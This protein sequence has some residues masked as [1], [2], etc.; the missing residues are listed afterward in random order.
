MSNCWEDVS[1]C[2]VRKPD[3]CSPTIQTGVTHAKCPTLDI[4]SMGL[5]PPRTS[6]QPILKGNKVLWQNFGHNLALKGCETNNIEKVSLLW[7]ASQSKH[8]QNLRT[9]RAVGRFP[10]KANSSSAA[11][12]DNHQGFFPQRK[13]NF[14]KPLPKNHQRSPACMDSSERGLHTK[15]WKF[16]YLS[17]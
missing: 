15:S 16:F 1:L 9:V 6:L 2:L 12:G 8:L 10:R 4:H 13:V 11:P 7:D 3:T 17:P 5:A 14:H